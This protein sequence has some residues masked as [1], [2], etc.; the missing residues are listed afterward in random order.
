MPMNLIFQ[1]L[2]IE[3]TGKYGFPSTVVLRRCSG[4]EAYDPEIKYDSIAQFRLLSLSVW[5]SAFTTPVPP[6]APE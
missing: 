6:L 4:R 5:C 3:R 1:C 2:L